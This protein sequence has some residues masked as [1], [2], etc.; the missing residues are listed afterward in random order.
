MKLI[1]TRNLIKVLRNREIRRDV[2]EPITD[3]VY[4]D[5]GNEIKEIERKLKN[6]TVICFILVSLLVLDLILR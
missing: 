3:S 5:I 4:R 6:R 1:K 2:G